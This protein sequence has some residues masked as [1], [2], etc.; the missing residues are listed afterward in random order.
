MVSITCSL[1]NLI[2]RAKQSGIFTPVNNIIWA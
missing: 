2:Q 1:T